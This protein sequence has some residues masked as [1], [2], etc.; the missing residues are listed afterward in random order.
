VWE[1]E[2]QRARG[3]VDRRG[4]STVVVVRTTMLTSGSC[5]SVRWEGKR[6]RA[7]TGSSC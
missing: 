5:Q 6:A 2:R 7:G 3:D 1:Q 4:I